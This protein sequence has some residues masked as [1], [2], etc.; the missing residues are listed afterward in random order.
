MRRG[1]I[2]IVVQLIRAWSLSAPFETTAVVSEI[3]GV[4]CFDA[5]VGRAQA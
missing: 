1:Y 3:S 5:V 2:A 4:R